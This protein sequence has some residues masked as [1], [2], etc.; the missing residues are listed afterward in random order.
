MRTAV[1]NSLNIIES[2]H[3]RRRGDAT[4]FTQRIHLGGRF[5]QLGIVELARRAETLGKVLISNQA[6][7]DA[8]NQNLV[9]V[10][11]GFSGFDDYAEQGVGIGMTHC[12]VCLNV[13]IFGIRSKIDGRPPFSFGMVFG[14]LDEALYLGPGFDMRNN[15][16]LT[17]AI[18]QARYVLIGK[19]RDADHR[20]HAGR[21]GVVA[22]ID[23]RFQI[24]G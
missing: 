17:T 3:G 21:M 7:V 2:G 23:H 24:V 12:R 9:H 13:F 10:L 22:Q 19:V 6:Q 16:T 8:G 14:Q 18:E 4:L 5:E 15:Q 1:N 11:H 20:G